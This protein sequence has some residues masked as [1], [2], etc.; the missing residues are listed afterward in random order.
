MTKT[1]RWHQAG[2]GLDLVLIHGWGM[3]S[4]VWKNVIPLLASEYCVH[5]C[6]L[7]GYGEN[8][9]VVIEDA[10]A[11]VPT[12]LQNAPEQA[13][14]LGW[15][16]GG[17]L[18]TQA[19]LQAPD[20]ILGVITVASSPK[21]VAEKETGWAGMALPVLQNFEKQL[22]DDHEATIG[23][24]MALQVMGSPQPRQDIKTLKL[25]ICD[26]PSPDPKALFRDLR[27]LEKWDLREQLRDLAVPSFAILGRLDALVPSSVAVSLLD[28]APKSVI[29]VC[30]QATHAPFISH[31]ETFVDVLNAW[32]T[33][34]R[35]H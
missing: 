1:M 13:I 30:R 29:H 4:G 26:R 22:L 20:R 17:L 31:P 33:S 15:S 14:W 27:I 21:F 24:F 8:K 2:Q 23:R 10:T 12:L 9:D 11:L 3:N 34:Q 5:W 28:H 35:F 19:A 16:L 32:L 25:A 6:D 18:V 7:P